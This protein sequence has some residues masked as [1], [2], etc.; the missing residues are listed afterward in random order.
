MTRTP[1]TA[2]SAPLTCPTC[3]GSGTF[4]FGSWYGKCKKCD[5]S[6]ALVLTVRCS[7]SP[8]ALTRSEWARLRWPA[9]AVEGKRETNWWDE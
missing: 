1:Y 5:G 3:G 7:G 2:T 9:L 4:V 6:G 8:E